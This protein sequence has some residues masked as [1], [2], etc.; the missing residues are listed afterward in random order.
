[1]FLSIVLIGQKSTVKSSWSVLDKV[2]RVEYPPERIR[3]LKISDKSFQFYHRSNHPAFVITDYKNEQTISSDKTNKQRL[4]SI[5]TQKLDQSSNS[6]LKF[7]KTE[8]HFDTHLNL[9][10]TI[11]YSWNSNGISGNQL[12]AIYKGDYVYDAS[13]KN[14]SNAHYKWNFEKKG[15]DGVVKE[16]YVFNEN[17]DTLSYITYSG[18]ETGQWMYGIKEEFKFD[19]NRN[20]KEHIY[21]N[22]IHQSDWV[23]DSKYVF[24]YNDRGEKTSQVGYDNHHNQWLLSPLFGK[25]EYN[26][27]STGV[28]TSMIYSNWSMDNGFTFL[29]KDSYQYYSNGKLFRDIVYHWD[30][31]TK[32]WSKKNRTEFA[33]DTNGYLTLE[34]NSDWDS[35]KW[36]KRSKTKYAFDMKGNRTLEAI[37]NWDPDSNQWEGTSAKF[38]STYDYNGNNTFFILS[39]WDSVNRRWVGSNK[40]EIFFNYS[41]SM[42]DMIFPWILDYNMPTEENDYYFTDNKWTLEKKTKYFYTE[43]E[44]PSSLTSVFG[45]NMSLYPNPASDYVTLNPGLSTDQFV[46]ELMDMQGKTCLKVQIAGKNQ[47][48]LMKLPKGLYIFRVSNTNKVFNGKLV[49]K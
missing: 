47:I 12:T 39:E 15:W 48:S 7:Q 31:S 33:Y 16:E 30:I 38:E 11:T 20:L 35:V 2:Q 13:G 27:N 18:D 10:Q 1:M 3:S 43:Q 36:V 34:T 44:K 21:Y 22:W 46:F 42:N 19:H 23:G 49:I 32:K 37:F 40:S 14:V 41:Y 6:Y 25:L 4:D 24:S 17:G 45:N 28:L 9:T 26:Y 8:F 5:V 29:I